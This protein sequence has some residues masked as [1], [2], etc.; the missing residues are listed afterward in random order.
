MTGSPILALSESPNL[1]GLNFLLDFIFKTARSERGSAP[2]TL[3]SYS[4]PPSNLIKT[5]AA[6]TTY[7]GDNFKIN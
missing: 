2:I 5:P 4:C 7:F 3:A 1:T 6:V